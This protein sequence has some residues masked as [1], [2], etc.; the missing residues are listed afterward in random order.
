MST[1]TTKRSVILLS[2]IAAVL[3]AIVSGRT[4]ING[5]LNDGVIASSKVDVTGNQA[6]PGYF[7]IALVAVAG[8]LAAATAGRIAR[9]PAALVSLIASVALLVVT[10]LTLGDPASAVKTRM[11]SVTGHNGEAVARGTFTPWFWA[12]VFAGLLSVAASLLALLGVRRWAGLSR[13][14]DAPTETKAPTTHESDWDLMNRGID[15]TDTETA[16]GSH[17]PDGPDT[18]TQNSSSTRVTETSAAQ[19]GSKEK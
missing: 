6:V 12:A 9:W 4:W 10:L 17:E 19:H 16:P 3:A 2:L 11:T 15:P 7:G 18:M 8:V 14:Y 13:R 5:S 1:F